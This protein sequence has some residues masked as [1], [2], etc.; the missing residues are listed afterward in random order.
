MLK[1]KRS[2]VRFPVR[3]WDFSNWPSSSSRIMALGSTQ[4]LTEMS[5]RN[6]PGGVKGGRRVRLTTLPPS[7]SRL[8]KENVGASTFHKPTSL[9]GLLQGQLY[10]YFTSKRI[11]WKCAGILQH[12]IRNSL[13]LYRRLYCLRAPNLQ[14]HE[15]NSGFLLNIV[16][17]LSY[18]LLKHGSTK[19][20]YFPPVYLDIPMQNPISI[21]GLYRLFFRILSDNTTV[22]TYWL[23]GFIVAAFNSHAFASPVTGQWEWPIQIKPL[24]A[25]K[26][27]PIL[28]ADTGTLL[29]S[30]A[31]DVGGT[32]LCL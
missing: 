2:R 27:Q 15:L 11:Y 8:F 31:I 19:G 20:W 16:T 12:K 23:R 14:S 17:K 3:S 18:R 5:I 10:L 13:H 24:K 26:E 7:V 30:V 29:I 25:T 22:C 21:S 28:C 1:A 4:P 32:T 9:H 6:V